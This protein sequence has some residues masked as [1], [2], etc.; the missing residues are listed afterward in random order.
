MV[1]AEN[2]ERGGF[3]KC[4]AYYTLELSFNFPDSFNI[5]K[6]TLVKILVLSRKSRKQ[7]FGNRPCLVCSLRPNVSQPVRIFTVT[8]LLLTGKMESLIPR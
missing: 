3:L 1:R 6:A 4:C 7:D 2:K 8:H 5:F